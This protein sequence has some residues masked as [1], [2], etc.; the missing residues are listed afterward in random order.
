MGKVII[1][2]QEALKALYLDTDLT[3]IASIQSAIKEIQESVFTTGKEKYLEALTA[4]KE[5]K[6]PRAIKY[7]K[8]LSFGGYK[9]MILK[10][11]G[12]I[13]SALLVLI[14]MIA[15]PDLDDAPDLM[16]LLVW[17]GIGAQIYLYVLKSAWDKLTL[18]G[19]VMHSAIKG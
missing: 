17:V 13:I 5:G 14:I 2:N 18:S 16:Y 19:L 10:N 8:I 1:E 6:I 12:W 7:N 9:A 11:I 3:D 15:Y 4:A